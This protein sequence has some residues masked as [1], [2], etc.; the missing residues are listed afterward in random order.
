MYIPAFIEDDEIID[1]LNEKGIR[2]VSQVYRRVIPGTQVADGT[3]FMRCVFP[4]NV[5]ALPWT[6]PFKVGKTHR[7]AIWTFAYV[8]S[9]LSFCCMVRSATFTFKR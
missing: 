4:P 1:K 6:I 5:V 2:V 8:F 7:I 3:R 9:S